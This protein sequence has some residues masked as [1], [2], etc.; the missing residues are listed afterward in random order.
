MQV[1]QPISERKNKAEVGKVVDV[2]I[3]QEHPETGERIGRSR[4]FSPEVDGLVYVEG[5]AQLG[6]IVPVEVKDADIY[7]LYGKVISL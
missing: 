4:R 7:D 3:E 2:L 6:A 1:Q 5:K